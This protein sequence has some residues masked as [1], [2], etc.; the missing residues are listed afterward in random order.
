MF[1]V[2]VCSLRRDKNIWQIKSTF[3]HLVSNFN[4]V[5]VWTRSSVKQIPHLRMSVASRNFIP[6]W[7]INT[8]KIKKVDTL[9]SFPS[10][11]EQERRAIRK[12]STILHNNAFYPSQADFGQ[13]LFAIAIPS[14]LQSHLVL[15]N[16][17]NCVDSICYPSAISCFFGICSLFTPIMASSLS[18]KYCTRCI[19]SIRMTRTLSMHPMHAIR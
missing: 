14:C 2:Y 18:G 3:P 6:C 16:E 9:S 11:P 12:E 15:A 7:S 19:H 17:R 1:Y 5:C 8:R 13:P 4:S 10:C